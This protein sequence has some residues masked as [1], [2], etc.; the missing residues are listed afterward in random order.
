VDVRHD[1]VPDLALLR[2]RHVVVDVLDVRA[3]LRNLRLR[4]VEPQLPLRLR[5]R[6][7]EPPP[8]GELHVVRKQALHLFARVT[9]AQRVLEPV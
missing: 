6:D 9:L 3:H 4:D 2:L 7:P 8:R 5:E 1:V